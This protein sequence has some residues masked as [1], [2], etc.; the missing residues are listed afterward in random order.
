MGPLKIQGP[1]QMSTLPIVKDYNDQS[2]ADFR[3]FKLIINLF[4]LFVFE[5]LSF[6][7]VPKLQHKPGQS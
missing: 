2:W 6:L 7:K 1:W 5:N 3:F 4:N